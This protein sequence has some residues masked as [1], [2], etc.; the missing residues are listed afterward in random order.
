MLVAI[1]NH[2]N[3][4]HRPSHILNIVAGTRIDGTEI[5]A[6][7]ISGH[8]GAEACT[9]ATRPPTG[10]GGGATLQVIGPWSRTDC[11]AKGVVASV[12]LHVLE[13]FVATGLV[14][15]P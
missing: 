10:S 7:D 3:S 12:F 1:L 13:D 9:G 4:G 8:E 6:A 2:R 11:S 15:P 14:H 5:R